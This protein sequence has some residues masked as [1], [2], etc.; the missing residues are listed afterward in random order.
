MYI[1]LERPPKFF[2]HFVG[3][4]IKYQKYPLFK[5]RTRKWKWEWNVLTDNKFCK[6]NNQARVATV[7]MK[8][9]LK[10]VTGRKIALLPAAPFSLSTNSNVNAKAT[11]HLS[12]SSE[13]LLKNY[14][15]NFGEYRGFH[16]PHYQFSGRRPK[17]EGCSFPS[18]HIFANPF[19]W[20]CLVNGPKFFVSPTVELLFFWQYY[21]AFYLPLSWQFK[22]YSDLK[23]NRVCIQGASG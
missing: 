22:N 12:H 21:F 4:W 16:P 20:A 9:K 2:T 3:H 5:V 6:R 18:F 1:E 17:G 13:V 23:K 10:V 15:I 14:I 19:L 8:G 7:E 11:T